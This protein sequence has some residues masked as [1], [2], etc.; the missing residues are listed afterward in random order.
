MS[1]NLINY[2]AV[3]KN[4]HTIGITMIATIMLT[5]TKPPPHLT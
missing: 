2:A 4:G 3:G 5:A 1:L